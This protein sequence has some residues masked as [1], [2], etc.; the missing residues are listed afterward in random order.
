MAIR[1]LSRFGMALLAIALLTGLPVTSRSG[2]A[3]AQSDAIV[4]SVAFDQVD[5]FLDGSLVQAD[6]DWGQISIEFLPGD[7]IEF[8][9]VNTNGP[10]G[11]TW[12]IRNIPIVSSSLE[13]SQ[14]SS[15]SYFDF[16]LLGVT[17]GSNISSLDYCLTSTLV[18]VISA[19]TC[20]PDQTVAVGV[21]NAITNSGVPS[22]VTDVGMPPA[23]DIFDFTG[24]FSDFE[25]AWHSGVPNVVQD[26]NE[27]GPGAATNSLHW[28]AEQ[29]DWSLKDDDIQD[30]LDEI[31]IDMGT[32]NLGTW[33]KAFAEGKVK[34]AKLH[35]L[36]IENHYTGGAGGTGPGGDDGL[37]RGTGFGAVTRD[38]NP[39]AAY[40]LDE[41]KKGQDVEIM[42]ETHWVTV[43]GAFGWEDAAFMSYRD[44]PLQHGDATTAAE[45][46][47]LAKRHVA[48]Y[49]FSDAAGN[50]H[51]N[52]GNGDEIVLTVFSESPDP[53]GE[54]AEPKLEIVNGL[55]TLTKCVGCFTYHPRH[56]EEPGPYEIIATFK[57]TSNSFIID[58]FFTLEVLDGPSCPCAVVGEVAPVGW[59]DPNGVGKERI[60]PLRKGILGRGIANGVLAPGEEFTHQFDIQ[61]ALH[62]IPEPQR[63]R[64]FVNIWG[65]DP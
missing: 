29:N 24:I 53:T 32:D 57:N 36:P 34:F 1:R 61:L 54:P 62:D 11:V 19:P 6:S 38:G 51:T 12:I 21:S 7:A 58:P 13:P 30:T 22:D 3:T 8:V 59:V 26:T 63:F 16:G 31:A 48:T 44:D 27:C 55:L 20:I 33:D 43:E 18:P 40:V 49:L 23:A 4:T 9:N 64:F 56:V 47:A 42:T 5:F 60:N 52:I 10:S 50:L 39:S 25:S 45:K 2:V 65:I 35:R 28:L 41:L 15:Q 14:F 46:T 17:V 37:P